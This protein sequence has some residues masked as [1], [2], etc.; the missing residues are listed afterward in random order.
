MLLNKKAICLI[1][2]SVVMIFA[3]SQT[4][5]PFQTNGSSTTISKQSEDKFQVTKTKHKKGVTKTDSDSS[6][7][8][9]ESIIEQQWLNHFYSGARD[10]VT[11]SSS[12]LL[13]CDP[14]FQQTDSGVIV[15]WHYNR[16]CKIYLTA[17]TFI[18]LSRVTELLNATQPEIKKPKFLIVHGNISYDYFYRSK[19]DTP[20]HQNNFQQH[21]ERVFLDLLLKEKYPLKI[22]LVARESN[23]PF[24]KNFFDLNFQFDKYGYAKNRKQE[25][26]DRLRAQLPRYKDLQLA[27]AALKAETERYT[28]L[29]NWLENPTTMQKL[30]EE[31]ELQ[32]NSQLTPKNYNQDII[33]LPALPSYYIK[34]PFASNQ[35]NTTIADSNIVT[36]EDLFQKRKKELPEQLERINELQKKVDSI[37]NKLQKQN[38]ATTQEI[39]KTTN[40]KQ[41][42]KIASANGIGLSPREKLGVLLSSVK[43]F[44][45]GRSMLNYTELTAQNITV[46]G[47]NIEYNPSYYAAFAAGK[48][49]YRFRDF[50]NKAEKRN[51]QYIVLGRIGIG[52]KDKR[53]LILTIFQGRKSQF[54]YSLP[55]S[56]SRYINII[57]YSLEA[58]IKKNEWTSLSAEFAKSTIPVTGNLTE[59][60]TINS[61]WKFGEQRNTGINF[62]AQTEIPETKTRFSGFLRKTGE[63]FQSFSLFSYN[64]DQTAWLL[65][66]DQ[67]FL[68]DKI[69]LTTML[70]RNDFTNPFT[71]K[72]FKTST[73]FTS[74]I[75]N[76]R[77]PKYPSLSLGYYP[78]TQFYVIDKD[79]IRENAYYILNGALLYSYVFKSISMNS[80]V[81]YNRYF[82]KAT[83]SGFVFYKGVNY[84]A[85]QTVFLKKLQLQGGFTYNKQP[86]LEYYT[87]ESSGDLSLGEFLT[88]GVGIKFN[89]LKKGSDYWGETFRLR[90]DFKKLGELEFQYEKNH[91]PTINRKLY[92][93]ETGRVSWNKYF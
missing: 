12:K 47:V 28:K 30:V 22:S 63:Y 69:H 18:P 51:H 65:R 9:L 43:S 68:S 39:Y 23:S 48:I 64:T 37:K 25:L 79:K 11:F 54:E 50:F 42:N 84:Y 70:R 52:D 85:S 17:R 83:D 16:T 76:V 24:F 40:E 93:I 80:S 45:V 53:A 36:T 5:I 41:L 38:F 44:S 91:L 19:L 32:Y 60:K 71:D 73:T 7:I 77:F 81:I 33:S 55:D 67:P 90:A 6:Q 4:T 72:T 56:V 75:I 29:K 8:R 2:M 82:N 58:I 15:T 86:E 61:L 46:T 74:A 78:G 66:A 3:N 20:F 87:L 26:I 1:L 31:R 21:T 14:E 49:D 13:F 35:K 62:K 57:G 34:Q 27:E 59:N 88:T 92:P 10:S 89:Q